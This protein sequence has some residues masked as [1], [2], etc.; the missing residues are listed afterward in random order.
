MLIVIAVMGA[1]HFTPAAVREA[2]RLLVE[3]VVDVGALITDTVS[4]VRLPEALDR[5]ERGEGM[6]YAVMP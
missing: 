2:S 6:K 4:L 1:F 5:M 3:G